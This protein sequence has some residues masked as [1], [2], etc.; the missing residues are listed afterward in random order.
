MRLKRMTKDEAQNIEW[1]LQ[2]PQT[3]KWLVQCVICQRVGYR[4]N[5]PEKF[6]GRKHLVAYFEP[7]ELN[8]NGICKQCQSGLKN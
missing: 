6:F 5:A 7:L 3:R 4:Y 2:H 8:E 1:H